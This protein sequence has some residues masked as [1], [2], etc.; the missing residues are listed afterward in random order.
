[1]SD[2]PGLKIAFIVGQFPLISETFVINQAVGAIERGQKI[3]IYADS[4]GDTSKLHADVVK[5]GLLEQTTYLPQIPDNLLWR[6]VKGL[7]LLAQRF[8]Q[9]PQNTLRT[10]NV[11]RY[12]ESALSLWLLYSFVANLQTQ[13][14][15]IHCQFGTQ[16]FRGLAFQATN[17]PQAKLV[18]TFRG[19]D[20]SRF[21]RQ[22]G[23]N[24]YARL[25]AKGDYFLANCE[26][27]KQRAIELGCPPAK[28]QVLGSGLDY[29]RFPF[30][31]RNFPSA[32]PV[33]IATVGRLVDKKGIEYAVRAIAQCRQIYPQ[34]EYWIIGEGPLREPLEHLIQSL[35]LGETVKL[36][37]QKSQEEL[38]DLLGAVQLFM[39][40]SITAADGDQDAPV[41]VLK[42]AMA[43]GLPVISTVHGGI[44]ELVEDGVSGFLVPERD[45]A[46]IADKL[47]FLIGH[48][49]LWPQMGLAGRAYVETHYDLN[50]L[51][52]QLIG[53][54]SALLSPDPTA[55]LRQTAVPATL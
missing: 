11:F 8:V 35:D 46:A 51:N 6:A 5:Y 47:T 18:T 10:L 22:K 4:V 2:H 53:L 50:A 37:G 27:F 55:L 23:Q 29:S 36:L 32:E 45:A 7:G 19:Q 34:I 17:A 41:N 28:I 48:S 38:V 13:Y 44:P 9:A 30:Q 3:H 26:F 16:S 15:I 24:V 14:D 54:Y 1:M 52:D 12:G 40:P 49:D 20:I 33:R 21:V 31:T 39:A 25:F 43:M 42:E